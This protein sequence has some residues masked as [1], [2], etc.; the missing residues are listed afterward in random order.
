MCNEKKIVSPFEF[1]I[2]EIVD[3]EAAKKMRPETRQE[4]E[5][6]RIEKLKGVAKRIKIKL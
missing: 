5:E 6:R 4:Q 1:A 3:P 2:T